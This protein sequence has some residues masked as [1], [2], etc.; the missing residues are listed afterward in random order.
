MQKLE[1]VLATRDGAEIRFPCARQETVLDAAEAAGHFL[2]AMCHEG[3][4]GL[5]QARVMR[6]RYKM[7]PHGAP[8]NGESGEVLLCRCSPE[9]DVTI[10]LPYDQR[11][12]LTQKVPERQAVIEALQAAWQGAM[13]LTLR[14]QPDPEL[15]LAA[16]FTPGQYMELAM[17]GTD[18]RR[19]YSLANL[20]NWEG[21]LDFL[22]RLAPGGAFS[23]WL[24]KH[25]KV[26]DLLMVRGPFGHFVLD[27]VS[28]R[29]RC[30][31]GSG[32]GMAPI[33]SMLRHLGEFQ[34][35]QP[36]H[37]I[38]GAN[39]EAEIL[40][41]PD[42]N[43]LRASLP[44]L[45]VTLAVRQAE[46]EWRGFRG[47]APAALEAYL[48]KSNDTVDIYACGPPP[49]LQAVEAVVQRRNLGDRVISE[50]F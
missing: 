22:I 37:L 46:S 20:P 48:A 4:C 47:T 5:C 10:Q 43:V 16:E 49:M 15:G 13:S 12:I 35:S 7:A 42:L 3:T 29:P 24:G 40:P 41:A 6:G 30:F 45:G 1:V 25:A 50:R 39:R 17:P 23:T 33:L 32:C 19:A 31:V 28:P 21:R 8:L 38:F 18:I 36:A 34:D 2:P 11:Q 44:Q 26:G 14:L 9:E 27:E